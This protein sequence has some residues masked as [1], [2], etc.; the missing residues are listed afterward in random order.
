[1]DRAAEVPADR[2][3]GVVE[4]VIRAE[5]PPPQHLQWLLVVRRLITEITSQELDKHVWA[6]NDATGFIG[7]LQTSRCNVGLKV[8][9][10]SM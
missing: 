5:L 2:Q 1:M 6:E 4:A 9:D 7:V 10:L 3:E 8:L